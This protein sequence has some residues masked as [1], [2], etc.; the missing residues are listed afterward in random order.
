MRWL[1]FLAFAAISAGTV[2]AT[3]WA[4]PLG[5]EILLTADLVYE[6][7]AEAGNFNT[8]AGGFTMLS[9]VL[10]AGIAVFT[11]LAAVVMVRD[12]CW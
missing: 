5:L 6:V 3:V 1:L 12:T 4:I 8:F 10:L 2:K 7:N 11:G 9:G